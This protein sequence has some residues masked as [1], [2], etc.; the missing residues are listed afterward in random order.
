[1]S[2]ARIDDR[3]LDHDTAGHAGTGHTQVIAFPVVPQPELGAEFVGE[4]IYTAPGLFDPE[5]MLTDYLQWI[6]FA[7]LRDR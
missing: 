1:M 6:A 4:L 2:L 7:L 5:R 3:L